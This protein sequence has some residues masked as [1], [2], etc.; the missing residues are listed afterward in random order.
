MLVSAVSLSAVSLSAVSLSAGILSEV[1]PWAVIP[2]AVPLESM[3]LRN[4]HSNP[5]L[6]R[7]RLLEQPRLDPDSLRVGPQA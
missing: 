1:F 3:I 4:G 6:S 7:Q 2:R 5:R